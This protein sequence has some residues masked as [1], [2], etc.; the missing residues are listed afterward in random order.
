MVLQRS[1]IGIPFAIKE[2]GFIAGVLL[3]VL[4]GV[5]TD[6][7]LRIIFELATFNPKLKDLHVLTFEDMMEIPFGRWGRLFILIS[8]FVLAYGAMVAYLLIVKDTVP[9]VFGLKNSFVEREV[10]MLVTS[11]LIM[12]PL[13]ML[14]DISQLALTST[15]SVLADVVLVVI[16][17]IYAPV[18]Q[19]VGEAGGFGG[20]LA[21]NWISSGFFIGLGVI[22]TAMACQHSSFLISGSLTN[23][24]QRRWACVTGSSL[25][26]ATM[27][28]LILGVVGYLGFLDDT[29][30]DVL[31]NFDPA[32]HLV[33]AA[34]ALLAI[35]YVK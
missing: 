22:S 16:V 30:G 28:T 35:T 18:E 13:S 23:N 19:A 21:D 12:L 33:N 34:R 25:F 8:M 31:N 7:S 5:F 14:R 1:I 24:T 26:T 2:S 10:V 20:V 32:S 15:L 11:L 17:C 4:V 6:K 29:Q 27:L 3:L 9:T